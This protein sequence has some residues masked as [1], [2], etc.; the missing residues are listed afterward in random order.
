MAAGDRLIS[1]AGSDHAPIFIE[2]EDVPLDV[3]RVLDTIA[4][5]ARFP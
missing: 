3:R 5:S 4:R 2:V 1:K